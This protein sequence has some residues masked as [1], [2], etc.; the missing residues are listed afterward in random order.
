MKLILS[1]LTLICTMG[2]AHVDDSYRYISFKDNLMI[3]NA[4]NIIMETRN[5]ISEDFATEIA[6]HLYDATSNLDIDFEYALAVMTV[7]SRFN[8]KA[9]SP[10]GAIGLMQI[11]PSTFKSIAKKN[12]LEYSPSD[13]YD[14]RKNIIVGVLYLNY[15]KEKYSSY[16]LISAGYNGGPVAAKNWRKGKLSNVPSETKKYVKKVNEYHKYYVLRLNEK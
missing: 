9:V 7:E 5:N 6:F 3:T 12:M 13:I 11:M 1:L 16:E 15:L 10:C 2:F 8:H 4:A 14:T